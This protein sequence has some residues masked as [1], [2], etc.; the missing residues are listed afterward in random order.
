[1]YVCVCAEYIYIEFSKNETT[2][3]IEGGLDSDSELSQELLTILG[4]PSQ[5]PCSLRHGRHRVLTLVLAFVAVV[6]APEVEGSHPW[7]C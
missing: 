7:H 1:M 3:D 6:A 4:T 2:V 5:W